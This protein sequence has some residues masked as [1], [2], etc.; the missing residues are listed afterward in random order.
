MCSLLLYRGSL[1]VCFI[2]SISKGI[3][4]RHL[5][6]K[7]SDFYFSSLE[8]INLTQRTPPNGSLDSHQA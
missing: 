1:Q 7:F 3:L 4:A 6:L 8:N 5:D 2:L